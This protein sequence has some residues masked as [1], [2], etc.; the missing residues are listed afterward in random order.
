LKLLVLF[1]A[2]VAVGIDL[3]ESAVG[4]ADVEFHLGAKS[5]GVVM[6]AF[7]ALVLGLFCGPVF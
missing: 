6:Y 3:L 5:S 1:V 7:F 4:K 2:D